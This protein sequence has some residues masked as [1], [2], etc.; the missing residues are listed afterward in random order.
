MKKNKWNCDF[1]STSNEVDEEVDQMSRLDDRLLALARVDAEGITIHRQKMDLSL[2]L[3]DFI[4]QTR[5]LAEDKGL[6]V[7]AQIPPDLMADV[8]PDAVTQAVLN[9]LDNAIKY[10]PSGGVRL[11]AYLES[12][13]IRISLS[14][15]TG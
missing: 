4:E 13:L 6:T 3:A 5:P 15:F 2:L 8:D 12:R 1:L 7:T 9:L 10:T 14:A 11:S